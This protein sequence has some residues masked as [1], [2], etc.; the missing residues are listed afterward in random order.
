MG[1]E[2]IFKLSRVVLFLQWGSW[3]LGGMPL[4]AHGQ[5]QSPQASRLGIR[6]TADFEITGD[7][8]STA[9]AAAEWT[10]LT[11]RNGPR[12]YYQSRVKLLYSEKGI[13]CLFSCQDN[14]I[15]STLKED[16]ADLFKEDVVEIFFWPDE[17]VPVYFEYELSPYGFE[18]PI[19]I[20]NLKGTFLGWRPWHYEGTRVTRRAA[21][22]MKNGNDVVS[23]TAEFFIPFALLNPLVMKAPQKGA[24]WRANMYR[25]DYDEGASHW[26]WQPT[27]QNFHDFEKFGTI[28]FR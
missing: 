12:S 19:L 27:R 5:D 26:S 7:G 20:P 13:Y 6:S 23:W 25:I 16:F 4:T 9:W 28:E 1:K 21:R 17:T 10:S 8:N 22:I 11:A 24:R 3:L 14:Q 15:T 2:S 18:L